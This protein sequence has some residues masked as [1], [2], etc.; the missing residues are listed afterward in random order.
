MAAS[1]IEPPPRRFYLGN[2]FVD[3]VRPL[4]DKL[5]L[6][7]PVDD[8]VVADD[9]PVAGKEDVDRAVALGKEAFRRGP[10]AKF[11]GIQRSACLNKFADL[12]EKNVE[13]LAYAE[14]LPTGR[15]VAG[16]IHFDLAHMVQVYRCWADKIAGE[17]FGEDNGF[18][19][20][21]RYKPLGVC[22]GIASWNATFMYIGWK[23]APALAAGNTVIFKPS[24]KSPLGVLA[25]AP[26]FAE[27]GFP[28][29][30][31]QFIT[32]GRDTGTLLASHMGIAK[33]SFTGSIAAGKAVQEA[34]T[35]SNL[36]KTTL[37]LG[38]KSPALVFGDAD[39]ENAVGSVAGGFLA[40]SGQICVAASRVLVEESI[41]T[42]FLA[43]AKATFDGI[44]AQMGSSPLELS[45]SHGPVVDKLQFDRIMSYIDKGKASAQL[46]TGGKRIGSKGC[47][48]EPTLFVNPDP[49]SPI[50]KEEVFGPVLTVRTFKTEEEAIAMA[51]DSMYGLAACIYTS[52]PPRDGSN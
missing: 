37:E 10:W 22:A 44:G 23:L 11:T 15:P 35:R 20:L 12:V 25:L 5:T 26:L 42:K 36:K 40:N 16:I 46:L 38:G 48:I 7:N 33:I 27:A 8:S 4:G 28:P 29:G 13:R 9:V 6:L 50:W 45:T 39:F 1:G 24:E 32:G 21:V 51:N 52:D 14:S 31:V 18:A 41:A 43:A 3:S 47:F 34:A 17:S 49:Q 30:V 2:E 19:K